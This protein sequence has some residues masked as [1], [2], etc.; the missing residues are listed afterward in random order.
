MTT[1]NTEFN[2]HLPKLSF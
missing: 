1:L 2:W